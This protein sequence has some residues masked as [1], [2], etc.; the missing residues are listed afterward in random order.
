MDSMA[1]ALG[2]VRDSAGGLYRKPAERTLYAALDLLPDADDRQIKAAYRTLARRFHPD[3][4]AG[5]AAGA[6]RLAAVNRAYA[7]LGN[8]ETRAAY[9]LDLARRQGQARRRFGLLTACTLVTCAATASLVSL[10]VRRHVQAPAAGP[11]VFVQAPVAAAAPLP[12]W[13]P[14]ES[15]QRAPSGPGPANWTTYRDRRFDF[16]LNYP[17]GIFALDA[18]RSSDRV[19]TFVSSD[20]RAVLRIVAGENKA[21]V[22]LGRFRSALIRQRYAGASFNRTTQRRHWFALSGTRGG[23]VFMERITFSCDGRSMHGWQLTYPSSQREIYDE[24]AKL[25]LRNHPHGNGPL[26]A[27]EDAKGKAKRKRG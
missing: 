10:A 18:A 3:A 6:E 9:D 13:S 8:R 7:T 23:E 24:L 19:H 5:N 20:G 14:V 22:S 2:A 4:N 21:G 27:C 16:A 17:A 25:V 15:Q 11:A 26:A 1:A 12:P